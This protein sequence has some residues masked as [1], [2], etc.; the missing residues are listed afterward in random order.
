MLSHALNLRSDSQRLEK[1]LDEPLRE[2][3]LQGEQGVPAFGAG[4]PAAGGLRDGRGAPRLPDPPGAGP[5]PGRAALAV[6]QRVR[7][8]RGESSVVYIVSK[9]VLH[10][11]YRVKNEFIVPTAYQKVSHTPYIAT[12]GHRNGSGAAVV[13]LDGRNG[14]VRSPIASRKWPTRRRPVKL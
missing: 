10:A 4:R 7:V 12:L 13:L 14:V 2:L 1:L 3:G 6:A 8:P 5:A 9:R 11:L